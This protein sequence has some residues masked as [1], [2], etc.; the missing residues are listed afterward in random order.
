M[1]VDQRERLPGHQ[2]LGLAV[3]D[4]HQLGRPGRAPEADLAVLRRRRMVGRCGPNLRGCTTWRGDQRKRSGEWPWRGGPL[5]ADAADD[6]L[7]AAPPSGACPRPVFRLPRSGRP[8]ARRPGRIFAGCQRRERVLPEGICAETTAIGAMVS[9]GEP[10]IVEVLTIADGERLTTC[11]G[12]CRQRIREFSGRPRPSTPPV[13]RASATPSRSGSCSTSQR[14]TIVEAI[15]GAGRP[16]TT[17]EVLERAGHR[18]SQS[19]V[20]RNLAVLAD[21][22]VLQRLP[23]GGD[24]DLFEL[25]EELS[26]HHHHH[27]HCT[28][29]GVVIDVPAGP[30]LEQAVMAEAEELAAGLGLRGGAGT[31]WTSTASASTA[32]A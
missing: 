28:S 26:G 16:V 13:P 9:A 14:R 21:V 20:Y 18:L 3:A 7:A 32:P 1:A 25:A 24:F 29:C 23:T 4:E 12:G 27:L 30:G 11:C 10:E 15:A 2:R 8:C 31:A 5:T 17:P 6:L 19:S 22:G